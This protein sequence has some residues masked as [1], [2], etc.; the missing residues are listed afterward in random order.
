MVIV[1]TQQINKII[2]RNCC[3]LQTAVS[4]EKKDKTYKSKLQ[5]VLNEKKIIIA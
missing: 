2:S 4:N 5:F 1:V 3:M